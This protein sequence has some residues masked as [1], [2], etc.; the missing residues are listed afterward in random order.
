MFL[1]A[2]NFVAFQ[3]VAFILFIIIVLMCKMES[4]IDN[5]IVKKTRVNRKKVIDIAT[6]NEFA[7]LQP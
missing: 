3:R 4:K 1:L 7:S 5:I 6:T 2:Y